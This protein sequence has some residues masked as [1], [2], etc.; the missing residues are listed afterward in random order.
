M[1]LRRARVRPWSLVHQPNSLWYEPIVMSRYASLSAA[2]AAWRKE[3][4][5]QTRAEHRRSVHEE[6]QRD[7]TAR[8]QG[9][10]DKGAC[11]AGR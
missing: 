8:A 3:P 2:T 6:L 5:R 9:W 11:G 1:R 4:N 10:R 7:T